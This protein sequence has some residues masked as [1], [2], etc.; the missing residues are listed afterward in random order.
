[1]RRQ[2]GQRLP[3]VGDAELCSCHFISQPWWI[4]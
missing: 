4:L 1:M 3:G 2:P